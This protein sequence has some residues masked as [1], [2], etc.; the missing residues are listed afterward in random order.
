[1][2]GLPAISLTSGFSK[3]NVTVLF[4][5]PLRSES[6]TC[7]N[8][9]SIEDTVSL[10]SHVPLACKLWVTIPPLVEQL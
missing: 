2:A 4:D 5:T 9:K 1:M 3:L 10:V 6:G 8:F 7:G